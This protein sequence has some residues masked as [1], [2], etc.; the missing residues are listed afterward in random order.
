MRRM[1]RVMLHDHEFL[2]TR[3][4]AD[5]AEATHT[6]ELKSWVGRAGTTSGST[7][8]PRD[9][10]VINRLSRRRGCPV[11]PNPGSRFRHVHRVARIRQSGDGEFVG[12]VVVVATGADHHFGRSRH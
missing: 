1:K 6:D 8:R 7:T 10:N 5:E 12:E 3:N 4:V 9:Y 2:I 11:D